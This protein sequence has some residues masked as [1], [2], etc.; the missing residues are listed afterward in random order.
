[1]SDFQEHMNE[2]TEFQRQQ[3]ELA[4]QHDEIAKAEIESFIDSL[5]PDQLKT[6]GRMIDI[7]VNDADAGWQFTGLITGAIIWKHGRAWDGGES[8]LSDP[9]TSI[10]FKLKQAEG[11][12]TTDLERI[13][14]RAQDE[15][16]ANLK[17]YDLVP[18]LQSEGTFKCGNCGQ[19]YMSLEDR[20]LNEPGVK[21]CG[22]CQQKAMWG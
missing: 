9:A 18:D 15:F 7:S 1:M 20:M 21:G 12:P 22:G 14:K 13:E 16:A 5:S 19:F 6:L 10:A 11:Q 3:A 17:L 2:I 4:K 8:P